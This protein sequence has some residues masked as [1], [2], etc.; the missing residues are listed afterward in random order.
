MGEYV[1][2]FLL[3]ISQNKTLGENFQEIFKILQKKCKSATMC[4]AHIV[5]QQK[6]KLDK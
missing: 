5:Q 4:T 2:G 1:N 3:N 6:H